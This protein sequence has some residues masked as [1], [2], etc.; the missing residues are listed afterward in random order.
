MIFRAEGKGKY[1]MQLMGGDGIMES[2]LKG[3]VY[4]LDRR[5]YHQIALYSLLSFFPSVYTH[6][7]T[8]R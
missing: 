6:H 1:I 3:V 4:V 8:T 5:N 7:D 2:S